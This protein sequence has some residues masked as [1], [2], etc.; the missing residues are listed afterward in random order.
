MNACDFDVEGSLIGYTVLKYACEGADKKAQRMK[1]STL[2]G[3]ELREAYAKPLPRLDFELAFAG[4]CR[5]EV[6]WLYGINLSRALTQSAL[7]ASKRYSTL[8]TGRVQG[9]TLRFLVER[10]REIE[11]FLPIP[12]WTLRTILDIDGKRVHAE[13]EIER[14]DIKSQAE[15][16][17]N[18]CAGKRGIVESLESRIYRVSPPTPFDLSTL[19]SEAYRH[20]G[21]AP[22][23][24]SGSQS[25][26]IWTS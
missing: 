11:N 1:F 18:E 12:F 9:P 17:L 23:L 26:S 8:S 20:I 16:V 7:K 15:S 22:A 2:T 10:E 25:V 14:F 6:D 4:M 21:L 5:H 3:R 19:Q 13:Y 24:P